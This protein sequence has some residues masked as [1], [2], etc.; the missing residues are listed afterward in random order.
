M[1]QMGKYCKAYLA[2]KFR[3]YENWREMAENASSEGNE[4]GNGVNEPRKLSDDS[5]LYLQEN[6]TVTDG[7]FVD[8]HVIFD[9]V[10][11]DWKNFCKNELEFAVPEYVLQMAEGDAESESIEVEADAEEIEPIAESA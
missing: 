4:E 7:I 6:Y 3:G 2:A 11:D 10:N 5:I 8:E 1:A 9:D